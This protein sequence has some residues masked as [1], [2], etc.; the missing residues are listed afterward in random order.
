MRIA[1]R[2]AVLSALACLLST[3]FAH[4]ARA[5]LGVTFRV[6]TYPPDIAFEQP[7]SIGATGRIGFTV[8]NGGP[9]GDALVRAWLRSPPETLSEYTLTSLDPRR[10]IAP[11]INAPRIDF[12]VVD[13]TAGE[14]LT[15][16]YAVTRH[17]AGSDL[18]VEVCYDVGSLVF[19]RCGER[20]AFGSLPDLSVSAA[21]A[22]A[23]APGATEALV[24]ITVTNQSS[25][26]VAYR[27]VTTDCLEFH[28]GAVIDPAPF[29]I[30]TGFPGS[31]ASGVGMACL[32][33][34]GYY[35]Q[36]YGFRVGPIGA[37]SSTS[38]LIRLNLHAPASSPAMEQL[39]FRDERVALVG[40]AIAIDPIDSNDATLFGIFGLTGAV[41]LSPKV[42]FALVLLVLAVGWAALAR[43]RQPR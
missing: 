36:S 6:V 29:D 21:P 33:F 13:L 42:L 37:H 5:Q 28:A 24:Q 32:A 26:D 19:P 15:C 7:I 8:H 30:E 16:E 34:T 25:L 4:E 9:P 40:G 3:L 11:E 1:A 18:S 22:L 31:C 38:C 17:L 43:R 39:F 27:D 41:P 23:V 20:F 14:V 12:R 35:P 2:C 10:C